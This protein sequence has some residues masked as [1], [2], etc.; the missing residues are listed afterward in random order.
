METPLILSTTVYFLGDEFKDA[1]LIHGL[2]LES[3]DWDR[4]K[5]VLIESKMGQLISDFPAIYLIPSKKKISLKPTDY[6]CP[7]YKTAVRAG[8]LST[9]GHSTN[10]VLAVHL[11][12]DN[13]NAFWVLQ[14]T[15]LLTQLP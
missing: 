10:F 9:T 2:F 8:T 11:P 1:V 6:L 13:F 7:M 5:N 4:R 15:A 12:T 14:G 3:S